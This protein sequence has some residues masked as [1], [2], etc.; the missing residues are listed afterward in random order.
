MQFLLACP[1]TQRSVDQDTGGCT[2]GDGG[3][4]GDNNV[5]DNNSN[6]KRSYV[7]WW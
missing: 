7:A 2:S 3:D 5:N 4:N 6:K 1:M